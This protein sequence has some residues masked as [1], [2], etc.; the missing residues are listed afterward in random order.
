MAAPTSFSKDCNSTR[1]RSRRSNP[2]AMSAS[3]P[4]P[5]GGSALESS[6]DNNPGSRRSESLGVRS[7]SNAVISAS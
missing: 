7:C 3:S 1:W 2:P 6:D 5:S 4:C